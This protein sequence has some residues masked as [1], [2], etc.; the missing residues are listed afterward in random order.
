MVCATWVCLIYSKSRFSTD[1]AHTNAL[2][3][4]CSMIV[5]VCQASMK[6]IGNQT[7]DQEEMFPL[8]SVPKVHIKSRSAFPPV[9]T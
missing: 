9:L 3:G 8:W 4:Y 2:G 6:A 1:K 7:Q 5:C